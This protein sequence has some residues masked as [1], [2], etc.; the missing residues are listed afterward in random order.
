MSQTKVCYKC[1]KEQ[2]LTEFY[3]RKQLLDGFSTYC[4]KCWKI[5]IEKRKSEMYD[6]QAEYREQNKNKRKQLR[7]KYYAKYRDKI[8]AHKRKKYQERKKA[9]K[10]A[11]NLK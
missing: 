1:N 4:K 6:Q 3:K 11:K 2:P 7:D 5:L 8:L 10:A 9:A